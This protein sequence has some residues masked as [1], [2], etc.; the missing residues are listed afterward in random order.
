MM[1]YNKSTVY[2]D[3]VINNNNNHLL[4]GVNLQLK[5]KSKGCHCANKYFNILILFWVCSGFEKGLLRGWF[6]ICVT[7]IN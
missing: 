2:S 3:Q 7:F 6:W 5:E 1:N 4:I